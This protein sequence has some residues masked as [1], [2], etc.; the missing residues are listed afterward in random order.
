M[1]ATLVALAQRITTKVVTTR[2]IYDFLTKKDLKIYKNSF[3]IKH[4][5]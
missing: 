5:Q 1:A 4:G 2:A 3:H